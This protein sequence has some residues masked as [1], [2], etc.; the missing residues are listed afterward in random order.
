M[1]K[2]NKW[3]CLTYM[4]AARALGVSLWQVRYAVESGYLPPPSVVL[5]QRPLFSPDQLEEMRAF[6]EQ[7]EAN[8]RAAKSGEKRKETG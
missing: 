8:Q 6:F 1:E 4:G 7:A 5:K 2:L 3:N